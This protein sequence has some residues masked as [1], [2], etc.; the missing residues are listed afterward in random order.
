MAFVRG[1]SRSAARVR[2][3]GRLRKKIN[4]TPEKPRLVVTRSSRHVFVQI[5]DDSKGHTVAFAST[6]EQDL[7]SATGSKTEKAKK[8]G[9]RIADRAKKAGVVSVVFDRAG[10]RYAG[11]VA[12]VAEGARESGLEL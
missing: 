12:A 8:I 1:K 11:R 6:M 10:N 5:V 3:H 4:G 9:G 7:R 2:R